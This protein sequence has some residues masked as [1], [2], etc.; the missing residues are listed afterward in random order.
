MVV[1]GLVSDRSYLGCR[2]HG[3]C[4][5]DVPIRAKCGKADKTGTL[6]YG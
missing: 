3:P 5:I 2:P 6:H 1:V 4:P